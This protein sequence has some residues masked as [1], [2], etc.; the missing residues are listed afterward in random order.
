MDRIMVIGL[1]GAGKS[2]FAHKLGQ[3]LHRKV[4]HL[5]KEYY[6]FDWK[7]RFTKVEW[8]AFQ[9][10]L[11][12]QKEWI[13][14]GNYKSTLDIRLAEADTIIFFDFPKILCIYRIF[15]RLF[16]SGQSFDKAEGIKEKVGFKLLREVLFYPSEEMQHKLDRYKDS[17]RVIVLKN[18][19]QVEATLQALVSN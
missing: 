15:K 16:K 2:T 6:L 14:D 13:I 7:K 3:G 1:Q 18:S 5:D 4:I 17:K 8:V 9:K 19:K 11:V 12:K 10:K